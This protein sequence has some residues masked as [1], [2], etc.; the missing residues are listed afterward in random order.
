MVSGDAEIVR[1]EHVKDINK[2]RSDMNNKSKGS[3]AWVNGLRMYYEIHGSGRPLVLLHG[4]LSTIETS[5][6]KVLPT[7]AKSRQVIAIVV[8]VYG[9]IVAHS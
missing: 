1:S 5:F 9:L 8:L 4:G 7:F 2:Q 3:Y 6:S